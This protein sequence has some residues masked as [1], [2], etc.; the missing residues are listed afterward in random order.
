MVEPHRPFHAG[1]PFG[2]PAGELQDPGE[3]GIALYSPR[4]RW[5]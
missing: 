5:A 4:L 2:R 3:Q 1:Q